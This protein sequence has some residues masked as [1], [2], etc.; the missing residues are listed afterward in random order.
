MVLGA[1]NVSLGTFLVQGPYAVWIS[2]HVLLGVFVIV[3]IIMEVRED[4]TFPSRRRLMLIIY[5]SHTVL[6]MGALRLRMCR[7]RA[8]G[9]GF[10][11]CVSIC[12]ASIGNCCPM[13]VRHQRDL[14][15]NAGRPDAA[16]APAKDVDTS[17]DSAEAGTSGGTSGGKAS[18]APAPSKLA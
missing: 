3:V 16:A 17:T 11:P 6:Q 8:W 15:R 18:V 2:W 10:S 5:G 12:N 7:M 1:A 9:C 14:R 13:Q 4:C